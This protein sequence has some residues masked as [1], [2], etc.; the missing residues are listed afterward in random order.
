MSEANEIERD[1]YTIVRGVLN[2]ETVGDLVSLLEPIITAS[3]TAGIR[4]LAQKA[5]RIGA[6]SESQPVRRLVEIIL[7]PQAKLI[8]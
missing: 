3:P 4:G 6:L 1:G 8:R 5:P 7:G 2:A